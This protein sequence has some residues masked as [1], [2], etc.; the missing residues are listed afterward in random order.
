MPNQTLF[1]TACVASALALT[2]ALPGPVLAK[3]RAVEDATPAK[4]IR[5]AIMPIINGSP[6]V[7]AA[8]IMEDILRDRFKDIPAERATFLQATD[9]Q[10]LLENHDALGRA[11]TLT[12]RWSKYGVIDSTAAAGLDSVLSADAI[13][14]VKVAEWENVRVNVIGQG[15]SNTTVGLQFALFDL[16]T[17][18]KSWFKNPRE[19]R[20]VQE[21]DP[22]SGAVNYDETGYIQSHKVTDPPRYEDVASDLI[23]T[24]F[25]KFPRQ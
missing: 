7:S 13:L 10:R 14:L 24:A 11:Y 2:L 8:K 9:T 20:F 21:L 6:D 19:Q 16:R 3:N 15:E 25:K 18:R 12:D 5:V 1:R 23:R 17:L 22:S 4:T